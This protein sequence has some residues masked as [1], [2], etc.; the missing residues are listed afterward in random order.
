GFALPPPLKLEADLLAF[1]ELAQPRLFDGGDM[2]EHVR[3]A[4]VGLDEAEPLGGIEPFDGADGHGEAP[5][6]VDW[7]SA[8]AGSRFAF[9]PL[10]KTLIQTR[11]SWAP[12]SAHEMAIG[13]PISRTAGNRAMP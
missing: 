10:R 9:K 5:K 1:V 4:R 8:A 13:N 12:P 2:D 3:S 6:K 7:A 11:A